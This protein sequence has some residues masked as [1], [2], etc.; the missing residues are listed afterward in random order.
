MARQC[1]ELLGL[2]TRPVLSMFVA[3]DCGRSC[4]VYCNDSCYTGC[5]SRSRKWRITG[6]YLLSVSSTD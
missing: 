6:T 3:Y 4:P 1:S 2:R 5:D